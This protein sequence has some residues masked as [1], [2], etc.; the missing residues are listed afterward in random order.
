M[1]DGPN[2]ADP[3]NSFALVSYIPG[4]LGEFLNRMR[5]NLVIGCMA[6]PHVTVLPPRPISVDPVIAAEQVRS[7]VELFPAF[8]VEIL[9]V[10]IFPVT[11]VVYAEIG[12]GRSELLEMHKELNTGHL[13]FIEPFE[14]HPHV[15]LAQGVD[16]EQL[17]EVY[18]EA[19]GEWR[20][21]HYE[22][23]F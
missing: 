17:R 12:A 20:D 19:Q 5:Q 16:L 9:S 21:Y 1:L 2:D 15:T 11:N 18:E 8:T 13:R 22:R 14:Y 23:S 7:Q 3:I 4:H 6:Y 10:E